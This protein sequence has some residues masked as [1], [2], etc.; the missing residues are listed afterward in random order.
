MPG[1]L[2]SA[3]LAVKLVS[4]FPTNHDRG[5]PGHQAL[6]LLFDPSDGS[7]TALMDGTYI[8]A[9]RTAGASAVATELLAR[10]ESKTL[11]VLGA[12]VQGKSHVEAISRVFSLEEIRI[13]SRDP[14]HA[15]SL[16]DRMRGNPSLGASIRAA[17][18]FEEAV[19][20]ADIVCLC[21]DAPEPVIRYEW[22]STGTHIGSVGFA[23]EVDPGTVANSSIFVEWR[24]A[25]TE[26]PPAGAG[27]L[28]SL[29]PASVTEI[30]EVLEGLHPGRTSPDQFT[31]YK[32]TGHAMED[33]AAAA[34]VYQ[35][36]KE[37]RMGT[38]IKV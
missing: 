4:V 14:A 1:Y 10:P 37:S 19:R 3:G 21:T 31:L 20:G 18:T 25:A 12:G 26:G 30:G 13:A 38:N 15:R 36:A 2:P 6:I 9:T 29:D 8:T 27:E 5:L 33:A 23:A 34:L 7:P 17:D 32:S 28:Q 22:L 35:R 16:V 11:A 24:G